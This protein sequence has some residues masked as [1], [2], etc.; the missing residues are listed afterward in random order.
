MFIVRQHPTVPGFFHYDL[1]N[2]VLPLE[3]LQEMGFYLRD[4]EALITGTSRTDSVAPTPKEASGR[5]A[6]CRAS[7]SLPGVAQC[8][9][10]T[11]TL[12]ATAGAT[13]ICAERA[14]FKIPEV[15]EV[16][17]R[18]AQGQESVSSPGAC[19]RHQ[20]SPQDAPSTLRLGV[21]VF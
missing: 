1:D 6:C 3:I 2:S 15:F 21:F 9:P 16:P 7:S 17:D 18:I 19:A 14:L 13:T 11:P 5:R 20:S 4:R 10:G 12:T 8:R